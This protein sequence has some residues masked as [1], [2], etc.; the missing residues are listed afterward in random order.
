[1]QAPA[2]RQLPR[3]YA[4]GS[5]GWT[6]EGVVTVHAT[7]IFTLETPLAHDHKAGEYVFQVISAGM[8]DLIQITSVGPTGPTGPSGAT[9][10]TGVGATGPTG[11][12]GATGPSGA[13]GTG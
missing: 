12:Q 6:E 13:T 10:A 11:T 8:L 1:M 7:G 5:F 3:N 4:G 9:G 2:P